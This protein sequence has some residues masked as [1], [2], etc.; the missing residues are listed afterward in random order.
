MKRTRLYYLKGKVVLSIIK[1]MAMNG[2]VSGYLFLTKTLVKS[3]RLSLY[4]GHFFLGNN[5]R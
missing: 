3:G 4:S 5:F 1:H 2:V